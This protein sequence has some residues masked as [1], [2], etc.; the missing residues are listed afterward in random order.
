MHPSI[1]TNLHIVRSKRLPAITNTLSQS[2]TWTFKPKTES[3]ESRAAPAPE[4]LPCSFYHPTPRQM[5]FSRP[6][7]H[8]AN[9]HHQ[10]PPCWRLPT[11]PQCPA[12]VLLHRAPPTC[13]RGRFP[14]P[15]R[16]CQDSK[17]RR[18]KSSSRP[19]AHPLS[20]VASRV[21]LSTGGGSPVGR[22]RL[23]HRSCFR[24]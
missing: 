18:Q 20:S 24:P 3:S 1:K 14:R 9:A 11:V 13:C 19:R 21:P 4:T 17:K 6:A 10:N 5:L 12:A 15:A 8:A 16:L 23:C 22:A 7:T 2:Q